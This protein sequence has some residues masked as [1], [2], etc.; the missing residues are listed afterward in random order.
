MM[1][2]CT[3]DEPVTMDDESIE[4]DHSTNDEDSTG[5]PWAYDGEPA[6]VKMLIQVGDEE[7]NRRFKEQV[8]AEFPEIT[9]ELIQGSPPDLNF[10]QELYASGEIPDIITVNPTRELVVELDSLEPID[11]YIEQSGFDL[12]IF[13]EGVVENLRSRDPMGEGHLYG[14]PIESIIITMF[15]NKD[16]F[17]LMGEPYPVDGMTWD[18][19]LELAKRMTVE[20]DGIQYKGL[21]LS[22][23]HAIPYTQLGVP[24]TDP[25]TGEVLFAQH[26]DTKRFF[27]LLDELRNI[28]A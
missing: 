25:E 6:T 15:Y 5:D 23:S 8:E 20:R 13:R 9:L 11:D 19:T 2:G 10:L 7:F 12:S 3:S 17:D 27:D 24:S 1:I 22:R 4:N 16:I 14:L 28:P 26:P 21:L 18:E